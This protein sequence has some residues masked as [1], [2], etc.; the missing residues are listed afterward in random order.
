MALG[1]AF[2]RGFLEAQIQ[3]Q[4]KPGVVIK[5]RQTMDDGVIHEKRFIVVAID[6]QTVTFVINTAVS[7]FLQARPALLKCQV[8][9][10]VV[11]HPFMSHDS[12]VDCSRTR[13]YSTQEVISDLTSQ[14]D[15]VLGEVSHALRAE[16]LA[17]IKF[18]PALSAKEVTQLCESLQAV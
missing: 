13:T 18:S 10:P 8:N 4:L 7:V 9:M 2:P 17:A 15:W 6:K 5:M 16:M 1:S 3:R 12:Y 14:P 11:D